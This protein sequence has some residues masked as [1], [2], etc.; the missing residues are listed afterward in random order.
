MNTYKLT[1][2]DGV[3]QTRQATDMVVMLTVIT[4]VEGR[5]EPIKIKLVGS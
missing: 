4:K 5:P 3:T 1:Y 2:P